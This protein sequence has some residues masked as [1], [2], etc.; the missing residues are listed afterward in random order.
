[1]GL[2]G[3]VR[4]LAVTGTGGPVKTSGNIANLLATGRGTPLKVASP[5][6]DKGFITRFRSRIYGSS[7]H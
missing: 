2:W 6:S 5:E 1:M 4:T 7:D 3:G